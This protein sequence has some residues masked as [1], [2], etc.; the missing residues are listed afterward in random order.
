MG[1][2]QLQLLT[3]RYVEKMAIIVT[4]NTNM[5]QISLQVLQYSNL[6]LIQVVL[7]IIMSDYIVMECFQK[8]SKLK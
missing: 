1:V 2:V 5:H 6:T 7:E 8:F 4:Q 3:A